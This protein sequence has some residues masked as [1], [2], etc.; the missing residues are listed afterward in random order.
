MLQPH[1]QHLTTPDVDPDLE[2]LLFYATIAA[3][4]ATFPLRR[5]QAGNP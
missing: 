2:R 4:K 1:T 5:K 3:A